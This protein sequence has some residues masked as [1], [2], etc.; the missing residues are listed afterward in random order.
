MPPRPRYFPALPPVSRGSRDRSTFRATLAPP[1]SRSRATLPARASGLAFGSARSD[2]PAGALPRQP[3]FLWLRCRCGIDL[4]LLL[5]ACYRR[6][7][8]KMLIE[9]RS[10]SLQ[11]L[12]SSRNRYGQ[13][14]RSRATPVNPNSTAQG[15]VR[16]RISV[17][18]AAW[19][20]LTDNQRAGWESLGSQMTR[21]DSLGQSYTLNGFS[22]FVSVNNNLAAAGDALVDAAPALVTPEGLLTATIT[23]TGGTLS[24]A[25]T[26]TPLDT[27]VKLLV[28][29]SPQRSA[30]RAFEG[31]LRLIGVTAAAAASPYNALSAYTA[32][33]GAP[34]VGNRI[35]FALHT[36]IGGFRS[37]PLST[38][39]VVVT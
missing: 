15:A 36:T 18:A 8:M 3:I 6:A 19:R 11:G 28:Y 7:L 22:A 30:G 12:T 35:F 13:Y 33:F 38:S 20:D 31:D 24:I 4:A 17:N 27:G 34:V 37:G 16:T 32:R 2:P 29:A 5:Q 21:T 39:H 25:Y 9:P 26:A 23:S 14:V 10:G 1:C